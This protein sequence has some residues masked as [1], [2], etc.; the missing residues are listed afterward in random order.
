V[1]HLVDL[2]GVRNLYAAYFLGLID[3]IGGVLPPPPRGRR[4]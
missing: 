2:V 1:L 4:P 3:R